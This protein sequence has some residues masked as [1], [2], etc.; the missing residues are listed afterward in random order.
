[1]LKPTS[2]QQKT[3]STP[4]TSR[5]ET[6]GKN[7]FFI[8]IL[9]QDDKFFSQPKKLD[10]IPVMFSRAENESVKISNDVFSIVISHFFKLP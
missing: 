8:K 4:L 9:S 10:S 3:I 2:S 1:M 5:Q 6:K 7:L